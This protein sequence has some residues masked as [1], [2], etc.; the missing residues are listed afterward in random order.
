VSATG[1]TYSN[2]AGGAAAGYRPATE[3]ELQSSADRVYNAQKSVREAQQSVDD[4]EYRLEKAR[5][6][7]EQARAKGKGVEDA[8]RSVAVAERELADANERLSRAR[9]KA[10]RVEAEDTELRTKGKPDKRKKSGG[11]DSKS[12]QPGSDF[13]ELGRT[14]VSGILETL[15]LDGSIFSNPLE[16]PTV[17]SAMAGV[18]FLGG[19]GKL[20]MSRAQQDTGEETGEETAA[21]SGIEDTVAGGF[22]GVADAVG[23]GELL[24]PTGASSYQEYETKGSGSPQLLPGQYNP[25]ATGVNSVAGATGP[26]DVLS[27]FAPMTQGG[28][29]QQPQQIDN[30]INIE[31]PVGMDPSALRSEIRS[32]QNQRM[33]TT[34]RYTG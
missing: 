18:N 8:E 32:E 19:L 7:L 31:G 10:A 22:A 27:A 3:K 4:A 15:G 20:A 21:Q 17:K 28:V 25:A 29:Q 14:F 13:S 1:Y 5:K 16:W 12:G 34:V 9:D 26:G 33:R 11:D 30:S 23:V 24:S 6:R 2:A